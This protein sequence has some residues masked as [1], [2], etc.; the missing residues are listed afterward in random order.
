MISHTPKEFLKLYPSASIFWPPSIRWRLHWHSPALNGWLK[1]NRSFKSRA[2][3]QRVFDQ[4]FDFSLILKFWYNKK[5]S[6]SISATSFEPPFL[7]FSHLIPNNK[8]TTTTSVIFKNVVYTTNP[9]WEKNPPPPKKPLYFIYWSNPLHPALFRLGPS[10][11]ERAAM[12]A[13]ECT[14]WFASSFWF[15]L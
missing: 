14:R 1:M 11:E 15:E 3:L 8:T 5:R 10:R 2:G 9:V 4:G 13:C 7:R 6:L 12:D